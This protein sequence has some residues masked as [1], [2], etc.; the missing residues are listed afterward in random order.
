MKAT[1]HWI[2]YGNIFVALCAVC[3]TLETYLVL[4]LPVTCKSNFP[5]L[6]IVFCSTFFIYNIDFFAGRNNAMENIISHRLNWRIKHRAI[7]KIINIFVGL[8]IFA[9]SF[10]STYKSFLFFVHLAVISLAYYF[11]F[12]I[13]SAKF[14]PLR[15]IPLL[16]A[17][18]ISYVWAGS[19]VLL[20][21][22]KNSISIGSSEVVQ[23]FF[24]RYLFL[25][26]LAIM[27]DI[28]DLSADH[29]N[30]HTIPGLVGSF[31]TKIL[32]LLLLLAAGIMVLFHYKDF[33][34]V[35]A[36]MLSFLAAAFFIC[37]ARADSGEY[38]FLLLMDG[39]MILQFMLVM[40]MNR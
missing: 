9:L 19:S 17:F 5:L 6:L 18:V 7:I 11:S 12:E 15:K 10:F 8:L 25:F 37:K 35:C 14:T 4:D 13:G 3:M 39:A 24:E 29:K 28:R 33:Y 22:L 34:L 26:A 38:Y 36:F 20:P 27:F 1:L 30:I 16:K 31:K 21:A 32:S 2:F 40:S 23:L